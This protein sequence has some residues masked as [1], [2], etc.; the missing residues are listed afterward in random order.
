MTGILSN[1][2]NFVRGF[3]R[4]PQHE[5]EAPRGL[6]A[7]IQQAF[8][9]AI[10]SFFIPMYHAKN[11]CFKA[12]LICSGLDIR[13]MRHENLN[14]LSY[15]EKFETLAKASRIASRLISVQA[16]LNPERLSGGSIDVDL[17][18]LTARSST[19]EE[20]PGLLNQI[21]RYGQLFR[22]HPQAARNPAMVSNEVNRF[23]NILEPVQREAFINL[24]SRFDGHVSID[25]IARCLWENSGRT[26][27]S[28]IAAAVSTIFG[29]PETE[30]GNILPDL[31]LREAP[32]I[33]ML[34]G[35]S[36][37]VRQEVLTKYNEAI[38]DISNVSKEEKIRLVTQLLGSYDTAAM[39]AVVAT[40]RSIRGM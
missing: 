30:H 27:A 6:R 20:M 3:N 28:V 37:D 29:E 32:F 5:V 7:R 4:V 19:E 9:T 24:L 16:R 36:P 39:N 38:A 35:K 26:D 40:F 33:R 8:N 1:I 22:E 21:T 25:S 31:S 2:R 14:G 13:N 10:D 18:T 23:L 34:I 11:I 17:C 15:R 12:K